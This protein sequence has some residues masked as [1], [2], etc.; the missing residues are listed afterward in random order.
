VRAALAAVLL[1]VLLTSGCGDDPG[2]LELQGDGGFIAE[3]VPE[4]IWLPVRGCLRNDEDDPA[5]VMITKVEGTRVSAPGDLDIAV[6]WN[7]DPGDFKTFGRHGP[8]P[9]TYLSV[10]PDEHRGGT[11]DDCSLGLSV[12][13]HG[14]ADQTVAIHGLDVTYEVDGHTYTSHADLEYALCAAGTKPGTSDLG[15]H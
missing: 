14:D 4:G 13:L 6:S 11:L 1:G 2:P 5:D 8:P 7:P 3:P 15:C 12:F 9:A 10:T